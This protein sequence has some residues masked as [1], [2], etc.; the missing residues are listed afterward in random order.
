MTTRSRTAARK[1]RI[2]WMLPAF[3]PTLTRVWQG[4]CAERQ[5]AGVRAGRSARGAA[6]CTGG[7]RR[8]GG[9]HDRRAR[10]ERRGIRTRRARRPAPP[11]G[12]RR[13]APTPPTPADPRFP[14]A[15]AGPRAARQPPPAP[16]DPRR[17]VPT[18]ALA[19]GPPDQPREHHLRA[20]P[21]DEPALLE[22]DDQSLE[23]GVVL[24]AHPGDGVSVSGDAPRVDY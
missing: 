11:A 10:A 14:P 18:R 5:G 7:R 12:P 13:P 2:G 17:L 8:A 9:E 6:P 3:G 22:L 4:L 15:P 1:S 16:A 19:S 23:V 24:G 20:R 21:L